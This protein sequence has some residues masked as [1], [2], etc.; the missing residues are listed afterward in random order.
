MIT[1]IED[2]KGATLIIPGP[3]GTGDFISIGQEYEDYYLEH[4]LGC[5]LT[6]LLK[7]HLQDNG[8][9]CLAGNRMCNLINKFCLDISDKEEIKY[10]GIKTMLVGFVYYHYV[11]WQESQSTALGKVDPTLESGAQTNFNAIN[12]HEIYNKSLD[13]AEAL[14]CYI[15]MNLATYPE[16]RGY[17][18]LRRSWP[19]LIL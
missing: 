3:F 18:K 17:K 10:R 12:V 1:N 19:N 15:K 2:Y 11:K 6:E 13:D 7:T 9:N 16:Y 14:R 4:I 8:G 5:N